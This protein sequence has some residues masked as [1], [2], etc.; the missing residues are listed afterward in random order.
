VVL[1]GVGQDQPDEAPAVA[2]NES[3]VCH[4]DV[5]IRET[6]ASEGDAQI[7]HQ[8]GPVVPVEGQVHADLPDSAQGQ[9]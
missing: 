8:P 1:V 6:L 2:L 3:G 9:E 7:H 5:V 4:Q